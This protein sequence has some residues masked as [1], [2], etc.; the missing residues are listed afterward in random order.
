MDPYQFPDAH[1]DQVLDA[2]FTRL[3]DR[4]R[5]PVFR[6]MMHE[7]FTQL[8]SDEPVKVLDLGCGTGV[9]T[10]ELSEYL[11]RDS[12][13]IGM[14]IS[15]RM[16]EKARELSGGHRIEWMACDEGP[17]PF[18]DDHFDAVIMHTLMSHVPD[19]AG[20][21]REA[22]R[23]LKPSG[24]AVIFDAD[25]AGTTFAHP[26]LHKMRETDFRLFSFIAANIDVCR[27]MPRLLREAGLLLTGHQPHVLSEAGH[28]DFWL[29][30]VQGFA[31][32]IPQLNILPP[33]AGKAW[34]DHMLKSHEEGTFFASGNYYTFLAEKPGRAAE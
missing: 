4:G 25:Y 17:L 2:M 23:I 11:H 5:N 14:D 9:V 13:I 29:S 8:P 24:R 20:T 34:V 15:A 22:G 31:R 27:Q 12:E 6:G 28:G 21:L 10:R 33:E 32:L 19:P 18:P 30:S 16:I 3:E 26:D 7:Y 1:N